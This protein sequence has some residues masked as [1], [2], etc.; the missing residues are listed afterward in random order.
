[1]K[2]FSHKYTLAGVMALICAA[3]LAFMW[4]YGFVAVLVCIIASLLLIAWSV[5]AFKFFTGLMYADYKL[6]RFTKKFK[7]HLAEAS[8]VY[9]MGHAFSDLDSIGASYGLYYALRS[10]Y[11]V[12]MVANKQNTLA[13]TLIDFLRFSDA[14]CTIYDYNEIK[15]TVDKNSLLII[16]DTHRPV[17]MDFKEL[18]DRIDRVIIIDHHRQSEDFVDQTV[19]RYMKSSASSACEIVTLMIRLLGIDKPSTV[20][21]TALLSGIMLDTKNFVMNTGPSTF[22][23]AAFLRQNR[24]DPVL[25]KKMFSES[26]EVCKRKYDIVSQVELFE[27]FAIAKTKAQDQYTRIATAQAAD[28]LL[29]INGVVASFVMCPSGEDINISARSFGDVD[30]QKIM[31]KLGGGGHKTASACQIKSDD[32]DL[33]EKRLRAAIK[34]YIA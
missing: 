30:V 1:M 5:F 13:R 22:R 23:C 25:I 6:Y 29:A 7:K 4:Q 18:Y 10:K 16:V 19:A 21:A 14:D 28:E 17:I 11:N 31:A 33:V 34:N 32:F 24:A 27:N 8:T 20:A 2:K 9:I 12:K 26:V 3:L 15:D